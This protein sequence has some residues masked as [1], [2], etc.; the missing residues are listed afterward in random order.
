MREQ[1][2]GYLIGALEP[3]ECE[4]VESKLESDPH[5]RSELEMM[6]RKMS[7][8]ADD[9]CQHAPSP[10]LAQRTCRHVFAQANLAKTREFAV[11][12]RTWR[13]QDYLVAA[14][15]FLAASSMFIPAINQSRSA[16]RQAVCQNNLRRLG[17]AMAQYSH[18]NAGFFPYVSQSGNL[19]VSGMYGPTLVEG[20][21]LSDQ[22]YLVCPESPLAHK[23]DW[24]IPSLVQIKL[25][26][27]IQL[28]ILQ[29]Q[30]GGSYGYTF[31]YTLGGR[32]FGTRNLNRESFAIMADSPGD[33]V[34]N[35]QS[36]NHGGVG[37]NVLFEDGHVVFLQ[38]CTGEHCDDNFFLNQFGVVGAGAHVDDSVIGVSESSPQTTSSPN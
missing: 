18:R 19:A 24:K 25:A 11:K 17:V 16:S 30:I 2:L 33:H 38:N 3:S 36:A 6:S 7:L 29:R 14:G 32:Y 4:E 37:Q 20:G 12:P 34:V 22:K 28:R 8:L 26:K 27:G 31:G 13:V 1:L 15:I 9:R 23:G 35:Y 5:L 21:F 10:D